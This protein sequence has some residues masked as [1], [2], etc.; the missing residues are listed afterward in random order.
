MSTPVE[1]TSSDQASGKKTTRLDVGN[2]LGLHARVAARIAE[3][4][5][6]YDC[7]V[8]LIKDGIEA[9]GASILSI[10]TLDAP[11]GSRLTA[12]ASGDQAGE[13]LEALLG[14][15]ASGFGETG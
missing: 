5:Q 14:L 11:R 3:T 8:T 10:L 1:E 4:V 9:D 2:E 12:Q 6:R 7:Q 15:F 13:V